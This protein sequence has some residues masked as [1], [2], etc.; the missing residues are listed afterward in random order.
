MSSGV[1]TEL[2]R[3][4]NPDD[5]GRVAVLMGGRTSEREVSIKSG[6]AVLAALLDAGVSAFA[7]D[8]FGEGGELNIIQQLQKQP[9]DTV[10]N[11][12]HGGEGED[13]S[14]ASLLE[15]LGLPYTGNRMAA[16]ALAMDKVRCKFLWQGMGLP[17]AGFAI[18]SEAT[19]WEEIASQLGLPLMI[20]PV[21]E[22]S[23]V[24]MMKARQST[25]LQEAYQQ[26][27]HFDS[28]V[29]AEQWLVGEEYT[30]AVLKGRTLPVIR[31]KTE[32][33]FYDYQAK[34]V[35]DDTEYLIPCGLS[36]EK[37]KEIQDLALQAFNSLGCF[38]W[39]RVDLMTDSRGNFQLLEVNTIPGMTSHSLVPMAAKAAGMDF[40]ELA[41]QILST[42]NTGLQ[43]EQRGDS[44]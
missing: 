8:A 7:I 21:H 1:L 2:F 12:L 29:M 23:S 37:E 35:D 27:A 14:I 31:L 17:T 18:L 25:E 22:G 15:F 11:M 42:A 24:G 34:Y 41:L 36:G 33:E 40:Q 9:V 39:G 43:K 32:R 26:A 44:N 3:P 5:Y 10:F 4:V 30:V 16:S 6:N 20:K 28:Q 19:D 38:G 13:G